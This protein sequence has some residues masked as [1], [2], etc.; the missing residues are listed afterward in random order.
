MEAPC[1]AVATITAACLAANPPADDVGDGAGERRTVFVE[2]DGVEQQRP[3]NCRHQFR[4]LSHFRTTA[5]AASAD[6]ALAMDTSSCGLGGGC[7]MR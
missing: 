4:Q 3:A 7:S 1:D 2:T 5:E 6:A